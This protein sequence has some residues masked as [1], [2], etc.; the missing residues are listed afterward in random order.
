VNITV[1][2][3]GSGQYRLRENGR[4]EG[5]QTYD[6][7][8]GSSY[9]A[10]VDFID[11]DNNFTDAN[12]MAGVSVHWATEGTYDYYSTIHGRNSYDEEVLC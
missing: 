3:Y 7:Q 11:T 9:A 5:I 1:D 8:N 6:M 10:A 2:N 4:A 12:A